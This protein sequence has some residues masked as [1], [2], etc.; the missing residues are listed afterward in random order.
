[1]RLRKL[2]VGAAALIAAVVTLTVLVL[3]VAHDIAPAP[4]GSAPH[5]LSEW[6]NVSFE[7]CCFASGVPKAS[8][9]P[10]PTVPNGTDA[11]YVSGSFGVNA[12][13]KLNHSLLSESGN[14]ANS[15][16]PRGACDVFVAVWSPAAWETY[17][18]GGPLAPLWCY[19]GNGSPCQNVSG[20]YVYSP[21]LSGFDGQPWQLVIWNVDTYLLGGSYQ[22]HVY[23]SHN[24]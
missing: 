10:L 2:A 7:G 12:W 15:F 20:G 13:M 14:C 18:G 1:M 9:A 5:P 17:A 8:I 21:N 11:V 16:S 19:P 23:T 6:F 4:R 24:K 22:F 3:P